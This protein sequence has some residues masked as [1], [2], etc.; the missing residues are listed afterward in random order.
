M[1]GVR[2]GETFMTY[3]INSCAFAA[4]AASTISSSSASGLPKAILFLTLHEN[5]ASS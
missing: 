1:N 4:L 3:E 2:M 5:I